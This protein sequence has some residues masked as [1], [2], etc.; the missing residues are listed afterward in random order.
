MMQP[1]FRQVAATNASQ[2]P[3]ADPL[4][5]RRIPQRVRSE[6]REYLGAGISTA[7]DRNMSG[8]VCDGRADCCGGPGKPLVA[9]AGRV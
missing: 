4:S 8:D 7:A 9:T 5:D 3:T 1:C 2:Y 6:R